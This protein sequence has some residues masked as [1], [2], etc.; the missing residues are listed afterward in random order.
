MRLPLRP[1]IEHG[2]AVMEEGKEVLFYLQAIIAVPARNN[3]RCSKSRVSD[4]EIRIKK[5]R[6]VLLGRCSLPRDRKGA[7]RQ[8]SVSAAELWFAYT[9][10]ERL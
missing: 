4:F 6:R 3:G 7:K 8:G 1:L 9:E 2:E 10:S 5:C